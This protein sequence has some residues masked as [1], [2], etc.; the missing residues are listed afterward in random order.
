MRN[1]I[2]NNFVLAL[3]QYLKGLPR[4]HSFL[5]THTPCSLVDAALGAALLR[6]QSCGFAKSVAHALIKI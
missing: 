6:H 2:P 3:P 1:F 5:V 4:G